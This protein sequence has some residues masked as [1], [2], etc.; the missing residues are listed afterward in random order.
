MLSNNNNNEKT[1]EHQLYKWYIKYT[2]IKLYTKLRWVLSE[3]W[4]E[5]TIFYEKDKIYR[6]NVPHEYSPR[7]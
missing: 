3:A 6:L 2:Y 5:G 1:L 7:N 4:I